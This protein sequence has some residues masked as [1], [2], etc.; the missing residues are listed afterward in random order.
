MSKAFEFTKHI[1]N[2]RER[3]TS[4]TSSE[5]KYI[6]DELGERNPLSML[7]NH[8]SDLGLALWYMDDGHLDASRPRISLCIKRFKLN[9]EIKKQIVDFFKNELGLGCY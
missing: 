6:K 7:K 2:G 3:Y 1:Y 9:D 5:L 4:K 8:Y